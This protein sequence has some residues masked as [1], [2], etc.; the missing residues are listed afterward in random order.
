MTWVH[1]DKVF[2]PGLLDVPEAK[3]AEGNNSTK[4][5]KRILDLICAF[6]IETSRVPGMDESVCYHWQLQCGLEHPTIYGRELWEFR[7]LMDS[8]ADNIESGATLLIFVHNLSYEFHFLR[9]VYPELIEDDVFSLKPRKPVKV[10]LYGGK[11]ELRCSYILTNMSLGEWTAKMQ[12]E[13]QKLSGDDFDYDAIRYPWTVLTDTQKQYCQYDVLGL[14]EAMRVQLSIY[15][16]T[17]ATVPLTSTGYVRRDVKRV[18]KNWSYYGLQNVQPE[19]E[20]Y[21][22]LR[23]AFRGGNTHCNRYFAGVILSGVKSAD[24]SSAY[25]DAD[26]NYE[27]PMGHF[28]RSARKTVKWVRELITLHRALL[29]RFRVTNLRLIDQFDPI[30]YI[31]F[32]KVRGVEL[33]QCYIDN[34][35]IL[36]APYC[37]MTVTDIDWGIIEE[38]YTWDSI[39]ILDLWETR[40]GYLPD[41]LRNLI[42]SYYEAKTK[43]KGVVGQEIYYVKSKNLLNSIYIRL[44]GARPLQNDN[45]I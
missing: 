18:M 42:I 33:R 15:D 34:G 37:E 41:M 27:F 20:V 1:W 30:P 10:K 32:A 17:L 9:D 44:A 39:E 8:F 5:K 3:N 40:Y 24:K 31:S 7:K 29:I 13:H 11:I 35:R 21:V 43:L 2:V 28:K 12:V 14:V 38:Q 6:D 45:R 23:E 26:V 19:D 4:T 25:P 22:A 16:D 36:S